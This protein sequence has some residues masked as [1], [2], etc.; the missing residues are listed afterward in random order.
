MKLKKK[1]NLKLTNAKISFTLII[2]FYYAININFISYGG[3]FYDDWSLATG[4]LDT[5]LF[6]R[7]K[8]NC[9]LFFNT[10]PMGGLYVA[11]ITGVGKNDLFYILLNTSLWLLN[12]VIIHKI[13]SKTYTY[14]TANI[15]LIFFLFPSFAST[16]FFSTV[17]QSLGVL[18]IF[19]W[20]ISLYF[21]HKK[22][23]TFAIFFYVLSVLSYEV[24]V[25]LFLF[26]IFF[27]IND[28]NEKNNN[29]INF[30]ELLNLILKFLLVIFFITIFQFGLANLTDNVAPLKYAFTFT[31][32][33]L[34]FESDF[35]LNIKKYLFKPLELVFIDIP[36]LFLNSINF[37]K[38]NFYYTISY[39]A[40]IFLFLFLFFIKDK[41]EIKYKKNNYSNQIV[42]FI[43]IV[44][45]ST[46]VF[47]MYL[48]VSSVPQVN[49]YYNRGLLGLFVCYSF[50]VVF[51]SEMKIKG[52][53]SKLL[54]IF[55]FILIF[56]NFNSF[57][58]Q[59]NNAVDTNKKREQI[60]MKVKV[61]FKDKNPSNLVMFVPTYLKNNYNDETI[62]SEEVGDLNFAI[63]Y[64]TN[65]KVKGSRVFHS[66]K[67][68]NIISIKNDRLFGYVP[69]RNKKNKNKILIT[70]INKLD[71][72]DLYL[73]Y[74]NKFIKLTNNNLINNQTLFK[75][76]KCSL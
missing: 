10:R 22:N 12:G 15:F 47:I 51:L 5:D 29:N 37:I 67:C 19:F 13:I 69:S 31:D 44:I 54:S 33:Q 11:L 61:F 2:L 46:G 57:F 28:G 62:F 18:S 66:N 24:S 42:F 70:H 40:V 4:Y 45:S 65:G 7:I 68:S 41:N 74:N 36:N 32:N 71:N 64:I 20:S 49:G 17:T 76:I 6:E 75:N 39:M 1:F 9:L 35:F 56:L 48:I 30:N 52:K 58:I 26:N 23:F 27:F 59:K 3:I 8:I 25:V 16:V 55:L 63:E 50:A 34:I 14:Y 53:N 73:F 38:F 43:I 72:K 60:L 21:S